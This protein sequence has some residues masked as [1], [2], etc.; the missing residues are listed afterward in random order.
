MS[1]NSSA[2]LFVNGMY[3]P[4][5]IAVTHDP[6]EEALQ[7]WELVL[8]KYVDNKG[9]ADFIA[10]SKDMNDLKRFADFV[11]STSPTS[12]PALL[13]DARAHF[14]LNC[15]VRDCPRLPRVPFRAELL[16]QQLES[17]SWEFV[18]SEKCSDHGSYINRYVKNQIPKSFKVK[19]IKYDWTINQ[20]S[21]PSGT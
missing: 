21:N 8:D 6:C 3:D 5:Q 14:A 2:L 17:A 13:G 11:E 20:R 16:D 4:G 15:M 10:L 19:F 9:R 1:G 12:H 18:A 7:F